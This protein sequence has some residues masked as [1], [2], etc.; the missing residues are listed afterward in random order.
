[1]DYA[2]EPNPHLH[3]LIIDWNGEYESYADQIG[4]TSW[5]VPKELKINPFA[6]RGASLADR[7]SGI[8][9]LMVFGARS[10][11]HEYCNRQ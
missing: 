11:G 8:I 1:L 6:L 7:A 10:L 4:A 2:N 5:H 3:L 9:D